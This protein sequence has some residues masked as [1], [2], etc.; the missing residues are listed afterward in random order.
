[1]DEAGGKQLEGTDETVCNKGTDQLFCYK[2]RED[3]LHWQY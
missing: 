3:F 2:N 1:M